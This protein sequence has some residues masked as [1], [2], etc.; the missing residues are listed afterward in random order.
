MGE[1]ASC[2]IDIAALKLLFCQISYAS[3]VFFTL[4]MHPGL[5][6]NFALSRSHLIL[7]PSVHRLSPQEP[8]FLDKPLFDDVS[9]PEISLRIHYSKRYRCES[10]AKTRVRLKNC[11]K[12]FIAEFRRRH[13]PTSIDSRISSIRR[14][15]LNRTPGAHIRGQISSRVVASRS[16]Q[17]EV[18]GRRNTMPVRAKTVKTL[19]KG[20]FWPPMHRSRLCR[21][22]LRK[23]QLPSYS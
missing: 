8:H 18:L 14:I 13:C 7:G 16:R 1:R 22:T 9:L 11:Q 19:C 5:L 4:T 12:R 6:P 15:T 17:A 23:R 10:I 3:R 21:R 20:Y 2:R